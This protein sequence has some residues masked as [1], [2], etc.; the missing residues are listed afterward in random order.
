MC[1]IAWGNAWANLIQPFFTIP[2]LAVARLELR[3]ILGY[4]I[5]AFIWTGIILSFGMLVLYKV[6]LV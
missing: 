1:A 6:I 4:L 5:I 3:H 2:L